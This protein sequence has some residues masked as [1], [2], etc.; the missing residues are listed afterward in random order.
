VLFGLLQADSFHT[1]LG[2]GSDA[3]LGRDIENG[4]AIGFVASHT[5][6]ALCHA[7]HRSNP[8]EVV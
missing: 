7:W 6:C 5:C 3:E 2:D 8:F 1:D 4:Q